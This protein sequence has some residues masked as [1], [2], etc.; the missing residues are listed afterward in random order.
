MGNKIIEKETKEETVKSHQ[1][2][3][4]MG[5]IAY[6][7]VIGLIIAFISN[8]DKKDPFIQYHVRQ[9]L[10]LF[11][12]GLALSFVNIIPVLG[13]VISVLGMFFM[14]FLW[15]MGL[16]NAINK[17]QKPVPILGEKYEEWF[18]ITKK[19]LSINLV[20]INVMK[21]LS[22]LLKASLW[23][24]VLGTIITS[25]AKKEEGEG[26]PPVVVKPIEIDCSYFSK[27]KN[28]VLKDNPNA[29]IDY[30][31]TCNA[32]IKDDVKIEPGT[33]IAFDTESGLRIERGGS[34]SAIGTS[35]KQI[36]FTG[37]DKK[38]G[39]WRG[40][41]FTSNDVK[42]KIEH[43]I[44]EY[45]G[46]DDKSTVDKHS[47][48]AVVIAH[49]SKLA[50]DSCNIKNSKTY[51][52]SAH[53]KTDLTFENVIFAN[54]NT[55]VIVEATL[56]SS[57]SPTNYYKGNK[58]NFVEVKTYISKIKKETTIKNIGVPYRFITKAAKFQIA[59]KLIIKPGVEIEMAEGMDWQ[60]L[61][62][63]SLNAIGTK[64]EPIEFRGTEQKAGYW[65]SL[66]F[67]F[68]SSVNN[69]LKYVKIK[70][71][72]NN[73]Q[74]SKGAIRMWANPTINVEYVDFSDINSCAFYSAPS[75]SKKL[76]LTY[77][78]CTFNNIKGGELCSEE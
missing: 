51:G 54:N 74:D 60:I 17:N 5:V 42:N 7:T 44:I 9:S 13:W 19:L 28:A 1:G 69:Q 68:S 16:I 49:D 36:V 2:D 72:G 26:I 39:S 61:K 77:K 30:L 62:E 23:A 4:T 66:W 78:N 40:L 76:N 65:R 73:P 15:V 47:L 14:I 33:V 57:V 48:G 37:K 22:K 18:C 27:N 34:L 46:G 12:T 8:Q 3:S 32:N 10:G 41:T 75:T 53:R 35:K 52:L 56:L 64:D 21:N 71:A 43:A 70:H 29:P 6:I 24:V 63:G 38:K 45:A 11:V 50:I 59:E 20:K 67:Y 58:N 31:V 25:C 55:P